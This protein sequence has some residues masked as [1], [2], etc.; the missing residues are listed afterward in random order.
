MEFL[1]VLSPYDWRIFFLGRTGRNSDL[2][3]RVR[4]TA[5]QELSR[6]MLLCDAKK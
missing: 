2:W 4:R 1:S 3:Y 5:L 6:A